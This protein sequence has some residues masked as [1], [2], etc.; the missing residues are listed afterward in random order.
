ME[1][2]CVFI[3]FCFAFRIFTKS[4]TST[5]ETR[6]R[7]N[8]DRKATENGMQNM[9][10]TICWY[11]CERVC[12]GKNSRIKCKREMSLTEAYFWL[13]RTHAI[14]FTVV[15]IFS[16]QSMWGY[17]HRKRERERFSRKVLLLF[18]QRLLRKQFYSSKNVNVCWVLKRH[19][20]LGNGHA[21]RLLK[22]THNTKLISSKP[23]LKS[24]SY[25]CYI[26]SLEC[27]RLLEKNKVKT[28]TQA[29]KWNCKTVGKCFN[30]A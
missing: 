14:I 5:S 24:N 29:V 19:L 17:F 25:Y 21:K 10:K 9:A 7:T 16:S 6:V 8:R 28:T 12:D 23:N 27:N 1:F 2:A 20:T 18:M 4:S 22:M 13:P 11:Y 30:I 3:K 15:T 26:Y